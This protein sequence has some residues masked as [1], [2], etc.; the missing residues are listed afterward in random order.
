[1]T[2]TFSSP[3]SSSSSFSYSKMMILPHSKQAA[4]RKVLFRPSRSFPHFFRPK[5]KK[6]VS[7]FFLRLLFQERPSCFD[8]GNVIFASRFLRDRRMKREGGKYLTCGVITEEW[9][10][11]PFPSCKTNLSNTENIGNGGL[12]G[13]EKAIKKLFRSSLVNF[14]PLH[15]CRNH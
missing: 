6:E 2:D 9:C 3:P 10:F 11:F 5:K 12:C 13:G 15:R 4:E 14:C 1:M 7:K 8:L